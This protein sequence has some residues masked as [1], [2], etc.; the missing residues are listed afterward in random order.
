MHIDKLSKLQL[1]GDHV[2][3]IGF[4]LSINTHT[5]YKFKLSNWHYMQ[6]NDSLLPSISYY[7]MSLL[8]LANYVVRATRKIPFLR[9]TRG[10]H[11]QQCPES[12]IEG[13]LPIQRYWSQ[14]DNTPS[15][16][17]HCL[18]LLSRHFLDDSLLLPFLL[19]FVWQNICRLQS[20][21]RWFM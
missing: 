16:S 8:L 2:N 11:Y 14:N 10:S 3:P 6:Y 18:G 4:S 7:R 15:W 19:V 1:S 21:N 5:V 17:W 9:E 20:T 13:S 12:A